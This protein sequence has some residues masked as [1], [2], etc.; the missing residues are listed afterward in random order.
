MKGARDD[1][2]ETGHRDEVDLA[3]AKCLGQ[4][5]REAFAV[6]GCS[7]AAVRLSIDHQRLDARG[8]GDVESSTRP[9][10]ADE[11]DVN[12]RAHH[13][14]EDRARTRHQHAEANVVQRA[15]AP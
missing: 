13:R 4:F 5:D 3:R 8:E 7:E 2:S 1:G 12:A 10:G 6:E 14:F 15:T 11:C 9:I